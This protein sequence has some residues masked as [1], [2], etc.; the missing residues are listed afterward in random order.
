MWSIHFLVI[1]LLQDFLLV[2]VRVFC[3]CLV[4]RDRQ[5]YKLLTH[6]I[7]ILKLLY[8]CFVIFIDY[9]CKPVKS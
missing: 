1:T 8:S 4:A 3:F 9:F 6:K 2:F 5:N 7:D